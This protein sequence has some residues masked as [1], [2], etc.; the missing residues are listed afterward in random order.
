MWML[1][2]QDTKRLDKA[3]DVERLSRSPVP[4]PESCSAASRQR[5]E[6]RPAEVD[7]SFRT[8]IS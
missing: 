2:L 8:I 4:E 3:F 7:D 5:I 1:V 6:R